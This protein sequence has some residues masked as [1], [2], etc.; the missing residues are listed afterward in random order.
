[1]AELHVQRKPKSSLWIWLI[2][3]LLIAAALYYWYVNYYQG[4]NVTTMFQ[5]GILFFKI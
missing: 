2:I 3:I 4:G 5:T 1:M